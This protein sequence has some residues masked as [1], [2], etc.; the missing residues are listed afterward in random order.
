MTF[1]R[2]VDQPADKFAV[3]DWRLAVNNL[4]YSPMRN[5]TSYAASRLCSSMALTS[6]FVGN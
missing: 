3:G 6:A 4:P 2:E 1:V 5:R